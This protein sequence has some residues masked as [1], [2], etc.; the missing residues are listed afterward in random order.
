MQ[1]NFSSDSRTEKDVE[2]SYLFLVR[3]RNTIG[4]RREK[5]RFEYDDEQGRMGLGNLHFEEREEL[6]F[7]KA[8]LLA[9]VGEEG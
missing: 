1:N 3:E 6:K 2:S 4:A 7:S 8:G 5:D 9:K